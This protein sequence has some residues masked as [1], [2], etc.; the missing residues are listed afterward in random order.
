MA[1]LM[2]GAK[3]ALKS[4]ICIILF[5]LS[6]QPWRQERLQFFHD[7]PD[8][9]TKL[10][11]LYIWVSNLYAMLRKSICFELE[12][13]DDSCEKKFIDDKNEITSIT[14]DTNYVVQ[15]YPEDVHEHIKKFIGMTIEF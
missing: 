1:L 11:L 15:T 12:V 5:N 6:Q 10:V 13:T 8:F 9:K 7:H 4:F 2:S 14:L 3:D